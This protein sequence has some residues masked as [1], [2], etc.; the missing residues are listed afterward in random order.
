MYLDVSN[1]HCNGPEICQ[2]WDTV[3]KTGF[4]SLYST[5]LAS[6]LA[7]M[8]PDQ[9]SQMLSGLFDVMCVLRSIFFGKQMLR[10]NQ[11]LPCLPPSCL[12]VVLIVI[13]YPGCVPGG[14][15]HGWQLETHRHS[16]LFTTQAITWALS[17]ENFGKEKADKNSIFLKSP[18]SQL[19]FIITGMIIH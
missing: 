14:V 7:V 8:R 6:V 11:V 16:Q 4:W 18:S 9:V 2:I 12:C 13:L 1:S 19:C 10:K 5:N 17:N 3:R 15:L